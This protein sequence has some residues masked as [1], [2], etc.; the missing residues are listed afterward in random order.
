MVQYDTWPKELMIHYWR[1]DENFRSFIASYV[2]KNI[3]VGND[4][5]VNYIHGINQLIDTQGILNNNTEFLFLAVNILNIQAK[6]DK[7]YEICKKDELHPG[8]LNIKV[9]SLISQRKFDSV[10]EIIHKAEEQSKVA[11]HYNYLFSQANNLL[12]LYYSQKFDKIDEAYARFSSLYKELLEKHQNENN[13]LLALSELYALGKS[14]LI[15]LNRKRGN[16]EDGIRIGS[17]LLAN[18]RLTNNRY[19]L[20]RIL[21]NTSLCLIES[22]KLKE[23]LDFLIEAFS[24]SKILANELQLSIAANNIGFI[25]RNMGN[26]ENAMKYFYIA[27]ENAKKAKIAPYIVATETNIAHL[28]LDFGNPKLALSNSEVALESLK[29]SDVPIPPPLAIGLDLCRADIYEN[30]DRFEE[31]DKILD[32]VLTLINEKDLKNEIPKV[33]LRKARLTARQSNLG[34]S[35]KYLEKALAIAI[36]NQLFEIIANVKLQLAEIDL[37]RY[38]MTNQD[39]LLLEAYEKIRDLERLCLE[40]DFKLIL[41]DVYILQ[42]LLLSMSNKIKQ[43][44]KTLEKAASLAHELNLTEKEQEALTQLKEVEKEK[45]NLLVRIFTR[46]NKSIRSTI[47]FESVAKPKSVKAEVKALYVISKQTGLP[48]YQ[49]E[50]GEQIHIDSNLLSGLLSAIR[51]MGQTV[52]DAEEGGLKLIDHGNVSIMLETGTDCFFALVVTKET[53]LTREKLRE[54]IEYLETENFFKGIDHSVV[55]TDEKRNETFTKIAEEYL[56]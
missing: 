30:M 50:F 25:Y 16:M 2:E 6:Y 9:N 38:R 55:L 53:F 43:G 46:I 15:L 10:E 41:I 8:L 29:K 49:K 13:I 56:L 23:G 51:T 52:L 18:I 40:Q 54:F 36:E 26:L 19:L 12:Y 11:D 35:K 44:R 22:G 33:Y 21:N 42:G 7:V 24:F 4:S 34:E 37:L 47:S 45:K 28:H 5:L 14:I 27:L 31:S 3:S 39:E 20:N 17:E 1:L 32:E 48:F